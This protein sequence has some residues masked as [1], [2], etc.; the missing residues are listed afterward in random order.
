MA[1]SVYFAGS[2]EGSGVHFKTVFPKSLSAKAIF[3]VKKGTVFTSPHQRFE[4][5][6][7]II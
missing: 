5:F 2:T 1:A 7:L 3:S 4:R 6:L